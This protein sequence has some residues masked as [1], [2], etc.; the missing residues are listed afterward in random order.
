MR[1]A[2]RRSTPFALTVTSYQF[3]L[4]PIGHAFCAV[5][6]HLH[7]QRRSRLALPLKLR[8]KPSLLYTSKS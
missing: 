1:P 7:F 2:K 4:S 5:A 8:K 3:P 6:V